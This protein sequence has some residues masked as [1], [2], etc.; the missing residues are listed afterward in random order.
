MNLNKYAKAVTAALVAFGAMFETATAV[1]SIG[2]EV[3]TGNE[4]VK[5]AVATAVAGVAV[6]A[7]PNTPP[8]PVE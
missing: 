8:G 7:I 1:G 3:V 2:R 6:W 4:W 5:I